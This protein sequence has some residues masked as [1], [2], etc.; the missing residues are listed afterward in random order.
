MSRGPVMLLGATLREHI[1]GRWAVSLALFIIYVPLGTIATIGNLSTTVQGTTL[2]SILLASVIS[3]VP[4]GLILYLSDITWLRHRRQS[5]VPVLSV[6]ALGAVIGCAR[7]GSMYAA[8]LWLGIQEPDAALAWTRTISGGLQGAAVYP[9][10]VLAFSLVATYRQQRGQLIS[11]Q[12]SWE[13]R[14]LQDAREWGE[15]REGV[16][17]PLSGELLAMGSDLD[18]RV[19]SI[20]EASTAV[21]QRAHELWG[22]A[23]PRPLEPRIHLGAA[24]IASLR[25]RPFATWLILALWLPT[26][27]GTALAVGEIP[28]APLGALLSAAFIAMAFEAGNAVV[29][30][31]PPTWLIA[32]PLGLVA[33]IVLT[34]PSL[35]VV[36][37]MP[38][39][40]RAEY[41]VIN[42]VWLTLLVVLSA[43][44]VGAL[45]R[46]EEVL[47]DMHVAVDA[48]SVETLAQ[49]EERRRIVHEVAS[50]LHGTLQGR[51]VTLPNPDTAGDAVRETLALLQSGGAI[52]SPT[53]VRDAAASALE[54]WDSL[55]EFTIECSDEVVPSSVA[56]AIVD[57]LEECVSNAFRHGQA[58]HVHC[59]IAVTGA[60]VEVTVID[61][62]RGGV[63]GE[64]LPGLGSR[65]LD[66]CGTW[67][68]TY[69]AAGTT[70]SI[71]IP[72]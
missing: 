60:A 30:R 59:R 46:G 4:V 17:A 61:D 3:L 15:I 14:R 31:W 24:I 2:G 68:R 5:P 49:E 40:G 42:A 41:S 70:V 8:S 38:E 7:S 69:G 39:Q 44:V 6:V 34:S 58:R 9:L 63:A 52:T 65:I 64:E 37:G 28:R 45:R 53:R 48:A 32:V 47:A 26:A 35:A 19:I 16:I 67:S 29:R 54:P 10:A 57:V 23:Q 12:I 55:L 43:I 56:Q 27:L 66:R 18:Q 20:D 33:A 72:A 1:G 71:V 50:A 21:R 51:L 25:I 22:E 62:G 11:A 13:T 36:G